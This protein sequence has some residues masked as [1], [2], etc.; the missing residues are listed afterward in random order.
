MCV[1]A[2]GKRVFWSFCRVFGVAF[3]KPIST[4]CAKNTQP[5]KKGETKT[6]SVT[7]V[8]GFEHGIYIDLT[9]FSPANTGWDVHT[10][11]YFSTQTKRWAH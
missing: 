10:C 4:A 8:H 7:T 5:K 9:Y 3:E 2:R 1:R 11:Q 6:T